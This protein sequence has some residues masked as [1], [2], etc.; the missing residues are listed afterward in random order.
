MWY[1]NAFKTSVIEAA[2]LQFESRNF[3]F[4]SENEMPK[5]LSWK[6]GDH[7]SYLRKCLEWPG[8]VANSV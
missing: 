5:H 8:S 6:E 2:H 3:C 4:Q 7:K 1:L